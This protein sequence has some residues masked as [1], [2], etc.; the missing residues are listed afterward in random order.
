MAC[1]PKCANHGSV[2]PV[3]GRDW[4]ISQTGNP[5]F[6]GKW[7]VIHPQCLGC[8]VEQIA[9]QGIEDCMKIKETALTMMEKALGIKER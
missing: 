7:G 3:T 2:D 6:G 9:K 8:L 1:R 5:K 4:M